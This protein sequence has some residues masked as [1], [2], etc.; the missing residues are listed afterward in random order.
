MRFFVFFLHAQVF[1][2]VDSLYDITCRI[3]HIPSCN[4]IRKYSNIIKFYLEN[5]GGVIMMGG[6]IDTPSKCICGIHIVDND[7]YWLIVVR[8]SF[9]TSH[10]INWWSDVELRGGGG[11]EKRVFI[12]SIILHYYFFLVNRI[13][14]LLVYQ[15]LLMISSS[16]GIFVGSAHLILMIVHFTIFVCLNWVWKA[17]SIYFQEKHFY[18]IFVICNMFRDANEKSVTLVIPKWCSGLTYHTN[19]KL[20]KVIGWYT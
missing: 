15:I 3:Q 2:V 12:D 5:V 20:A 9:S 18:N 17:I 14:I 7:A 10:G 4:D 19:Q 8:N 13:H 16:E 11:K 1:Y 6:D